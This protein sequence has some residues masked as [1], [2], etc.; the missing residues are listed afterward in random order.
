MQ[1]T[2]DI[3]IISMLGEVNGK[4]NDIAIMLEN[5]QDRMNKNFRVLAE[6]QISTTDKLN[7]LGDDVKEI[8]FKVG[9]L[10]SGVGLNASKRGELSKRGTI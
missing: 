4:I 3:K 9:V 6:N 1:E 7:E 5:I 8:K 10:E 2:S